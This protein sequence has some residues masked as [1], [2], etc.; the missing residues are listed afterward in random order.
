VWR[1][2]GKSEVK[3]IEVKCGNVKC[4]EVVENLKGIKTKWEVK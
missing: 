4:N 3:C 1:K 2:S